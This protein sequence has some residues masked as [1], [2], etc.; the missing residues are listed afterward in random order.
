MGEC[1]YVKSAVFTPELH[2]VE[3][4]EIARGVIQEHVFRARVRGPDRPRGR[5][6]V[7]VIDS[8][9]ELDPGI[10]AHPCRPGDGFPQ[11][12]GLHGFAD[13]AVGAPFQ[14]PIGVIP[15]RLHEIIG[16]ADGIVRV[17]SGNGPVS[18]AIPVG[19]ISVKIKV[20]VSLAGEGDRALDIIIGHKSFP[21]GDN[22]PFQLVIFLRIKSILAFDIGFGAGR[23]DPL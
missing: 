23:Q 11:L 1:G 17:L 18:L 2:Q 3:R 16:N 7:P 6:G 5:A 22:R 21:G 15:D 8:G 13:L 10:G 4:G 12:P 19:G 20:G 9:V 14:G